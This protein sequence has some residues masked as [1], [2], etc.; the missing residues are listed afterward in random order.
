MTV[1]SGGTIPALSSGDLGLLL[2]VVLAVWLPGGVVG[3]VAGLRGWTLAACAPLLT[4]GVVGLAGPASS[5]FGVRWSTVTLVVATAIVAAVCAVVARLVPGTDPETSPWRPAAHAAVAACVAAAATLSTVVVIGGMGGLRTI[6]QDWD[7]ALHANGVRWIAETGDAG[8]GALSRIAL[9]VIPNSAYYPNA[10]HLVAADVLELTG[11]DVPSVLNA[12]TVVTLGLLALG[13][14]ALVRRCGGRAVAAGAAALVAA[15]STGVYDLFWRG[16]LLPYGMGVALL[17]AGLVLTLDLLEAPGARDQVRRAVPFVLGLGGALALHPS[18]LITL[19]VLALPVLALRRPVTLARLGR[20]VGTAVAAGLATAVVFGAQLLG[21]LHSGGGTFDWPPVMTKPESL[22]QIVLFSHQMDTPQWGLAIALFCG[23]LGMR[24]LG[25]LRW[26]PLAALLVTGLFSAAATSQSA[27]AEF[28]TSPWWNDRWRLAGV[29]IVPLAVVAGHGVAEVTRLVTAAVARTGG[30][31]LRDV[32]PSRT[33]TTSAVVAVLLLGTLAVATDGLYLPRNQAQM[34]RNTGEGPGVTSGEVAGY[35]TLATMVAPGERVMNDR[36]DGSVWMYALTGV[37]PVAAR[38]SDPDGVEPDQLLLAQ[39]FRDVDTDPAV[40][41]A[42]DRLGVRWAVVGEGF[43][44][45]GA[46]REPGLVDL[47][48]VPS[49]RR[50]W[51]NGAFTI[52]R[53]TAR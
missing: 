40:R 34:A 5:A 50:V 27:W 48:R 18:V 26:A 10:Y 39:R 20:D 11:R 21:L 6:P 53:L 43:L 44:R 31:W 51:S 16:P 29:V 1:A 36:G 24:R 35:R 30:R 3:A 23:L 52:Y 46:V 32:S 25:G 22:R 28:V 4:Y 8:L 15:A 14:A 12:S 42:A 2:V 37:Q 38:Y 9:D 17:P 47:D 41:A 49:L 19:V 13:V 33:A 7:A 45:E